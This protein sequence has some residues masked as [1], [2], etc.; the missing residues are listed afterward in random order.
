M[1]IKI[2]ETEDGLEIKLSGELDHHAAKGALKEIA[3]AADEFVPTICILDMSQVTF[4]D[5]SGIAVVLGLYRKMSE[6]GGRVVVKDT[7]PG[8]M[9]IFRI[10]GLERIVTFS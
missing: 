4:M 7:P 5:S 9:K 6:V 3:D 2:R 1:K 10:A 8:V